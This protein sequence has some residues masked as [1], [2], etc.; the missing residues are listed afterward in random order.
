MNEM[1]SISLAAFMMIFSGITSKVLAQGGFA[2]GFAEGMS[3]ALDEQRRQDNA[4]ELQRARFEQIQRLKREEEERAEERQLRRELAAAQR[5]REEARRYQEQL[6]EQE[7]QRRLEARVAAAKQKQ[8]RLQELERIKKLRKT[9]ALAFERRLTEYGYYCFNK[10]AGNR[11]VYAVGRDVR[12]VYRDLP[13]DLMARV[14]SEIYPQ[15][16]LEDRKEM[17]AHYFPEIK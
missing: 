15:L 17:L 13:A 4:L 12:V 2:A 16:S 6:K 14:Q 10:G 7:E 3:E 8:M 1:K 11:P 9:S 5:E